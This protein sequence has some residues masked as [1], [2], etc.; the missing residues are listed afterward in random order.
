MPAG[1]AYF[2]KVPKRL[3]L[4]T[5]QDSS[6]LYAGPSSRIVELL[7]KYRPGAMQDGAGPSVAC[8]R[9]GDGM[10]HPEYSNAAERLEPWKCR[11]R[12][13]RGEALISREAPPGREG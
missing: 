9:S 10:P 1:L 12:P 2:R 5:S 7:L 4:F 3:R 8:C 11:C 6:W 13:P